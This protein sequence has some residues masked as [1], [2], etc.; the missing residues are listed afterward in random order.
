M[1]LTKRVLDKING[2]E[3]PVK[4]YMAALTGKRSPEIG[5]LVLPNS[6]V[7]TIDLAGNKVEN[8]L[9]EV[10]MRGTDEA[11]I[12]EILWKIAE[13]IGDDDFKVV[14]NEDAFVF[15]RSEVTSFPTMASIDTQENLNYVLD[16]T[17]KVQTFNK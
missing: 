4:C 7:E 9:Y 2:L 17:I 14:S 12:N 10:A 15:I 6:Q 5:L 3:L 11:Q 1:D 16:F 13:M 8:F